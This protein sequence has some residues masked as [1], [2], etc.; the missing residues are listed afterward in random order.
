M[1]ECKICGSWFS[2]S[3]KEDKLCPTCERALDR[4]GDYVA[5][6]KHG[7]WIYESHKRLGEE[8][9]KYNAWYVSIICADCQYEDDARWIVL[10][11]ACYPGLT[12]DKAKELVLA[13]A[14]AYNS[15]RFCPHCGAKMD[16]E[17]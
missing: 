5:P 14:K 16:L 10:Y 7:K 15:F 11:E 13:E 1:R 4:L 2:S 6:V 12:D 9:R 8:P 3:C 17:D